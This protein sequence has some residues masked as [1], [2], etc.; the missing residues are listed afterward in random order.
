MMK[1]LTS[2]C[3]SDASA[4][5][6]PTCK[7]TLPST[8]FLGARANKLCSVGVEGRA[9]KTGQIGA[10]VPY[11]FNNLHPFGQPMQKLIPVFLLGIIVLAG[12]S[13]WLPR[14]AS[15]TDA[16]SIW[17]ID[18][19]TQQNVTA[20]SV[21]DNPNDGI[22]CRGSIYD[23]DHQA[24]SASVQVFN[25]LG[26][27]VLSQ[28]GLLCYEH[29]PCKAPALFSPEL[30]DPAH[31]HGTWTIKFTFYDSRNQ[32]IGTQIGN[33]TLSFFV[34]PESAV[35]TIALSL[36]SLGALGAFISLKRRNARP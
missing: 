1:H 7:L 20:G 29:N 21:I 18:T 32:V 27:Q 8:S 26:D 15:A 30:A 22:K 10:N 25:D 3:K 14:Q 33:I 36:A 23:V 6:V 9:T 12:L 28:T 16:T 17:C 13:L 2:S 34:L 4:N 31:V 11:V 19:Q 35:G 5:D 24:A